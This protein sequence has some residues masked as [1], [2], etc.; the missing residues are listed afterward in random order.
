MSDEYIQ[1]FTKNDYALVVRVSEDD[2]G[3][4]SIEVEGY[5]PEHL[6]EIDNDQVPEIHFLLVQAM[7]DMKENLDSYLAQQPGAV[8]EEV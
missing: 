3:L 7:V 2:A 4:T 5:Y 1:A 6:A 8:Q